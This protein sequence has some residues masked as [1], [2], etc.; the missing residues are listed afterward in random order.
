[1]P[2]PLSKAVR[3]EVISSDDPRI[4]FGYPLL[5]LVS[6]GH[7]CFLALVLL[8]GEAGDQWL[9]ILVISIAQTVANALLGLGVSNP[10]RYPILLL[11][12]C[13]VNYSA[14]FAV[15]CLA[16]GYASL[17][18]MLSLFGV[19]PSAFFMGRSGAF[20]IAGVALA[21][22][23]APHV[24]SLDAATLVGSGAQVTMVIVLGLI[25]ASVFRVVSEVEGQ[26]R[27]ASA[28]LETANRNLVELLA[29]K[30]AESEK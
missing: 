4:R 2:N 18:W 11:L 1:M 8:A 26:Q 16:G 30:E 22:L 25:A 6:A 27:Q 17:L 23:L 15:L 9:N 13:I 20:L 21:G 7:L 3:S 19:F 5:R 28:E 12:L 14:V 10:R 29:N 24:G